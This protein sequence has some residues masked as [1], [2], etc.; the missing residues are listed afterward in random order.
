MAFFNLFKRD[1]SNK[2]A[3]SSF[4]PEW[5][6]HGIAFRLA[7]PLPTPTVDE[8]QARAFAVEQHEFVLAHYLL[9]L[10]QE[11]AASIDVDTIL[12]SWSE[13]YRLREMAEHQSSL[14]SIIVPLERPAQPVLDHLATLSDSSFDVFVEGWE[15]NGR[16]LRTARRIGAVLIVDDEEM[17]LPAATWKTVAIVEQFRLRSAEQRTQHFNELGWG[18]IRA[19]AEVG[20]ALYKSQYLA[21]TH[22]LTPGKLRLPRVK[23]ETAF[24]RVHTVMPTFDGAPTGWLRAFDQY[25]AVQ[26]HYDLASIDGGRVRIVLSEPVRKVLQVIKRD[27][28]GRRV[29]GALAEKFIHN[30]WAFLGE[31]AAEVFNEDDFLLD[32]ASAGPVTTVFSVAP[33]MRD[34]HIDAVSLVVTEHYADGAAQTSEC[35]FD[36]T[37]SL[38]EFVATLEKAL[39]EERE[40]FPWNEFD[41]TVDVE[42]T[43]QL[44]TARQVLFLWRTQP[45]ARI[46][47]TDVYTL[48]DYSDRIHGIGV[49][50]PV[51]V[52]VMQKASSEA[53]DDGGW[54]PD[55]L[56]PMVSV[57]LSGHD[58]HVLIPLT[59]EWVQN[60]EQAVQQAEKE[61]IS[62]V[63]DTEMPTAIDTVQAR[64]LADAFSSMIAAS[65][66]VKAEKASE[67]S[68]PRRTRESLLVKTNF[69]EVDYQEARR[70][71]LTPP[72]DAKVHLPASLRPSISLKTHQR[73]GIAWFQHLVALSPSDC[74]GALLAD[75]MGL[76][77][78]LQLL[79]LLGWFYE[80]QPEGKPSLVVAPK[81]LLENWAQEIERFFTPAFPAHLVLHGEELRARKQPIDLIDEQLQTR[82]VTE[83]LKP[84][85][86]GN[87][88]VIITTYEVLT[89]YEFSF[90]RQEF[91]FVICD[92][93][94]RIKTP[95]TRVTLAAKKLKADFRICC[96]GTPVENSLAD[97]WCLF[98]FV[99][100]GL[101][102]ALETFGRTY[103]RPIECNTEEHHDSL[104]RL[105]L[106][107]APQT[108]RRTK[109]DIA[110]ELKKKYFVLQGLTQSTSSLSVSPADS[111]RLEV[112]ISGHQLV[113]YKGGL[114]KLQDAAVE[115]DAKQRA[116]LSF[117][118][119]HL[120]KAVCAEP[121][122]LPGSRFAPDKR[123]PDAHLE[124]SPKMRWLLE[125]LE[126]VSSRSEKAI[127]FTELREVQAALAY[128]IHQRFGIKPSVVNGDTQARQGIIDR[129]SRSNGF[130]VIILSTL[131]AGAGLNVTAAN[132]VF[133]YT[134]AWNA[135]KEN[136]A[137]D[138]AYR[139]GQERDVFVYCPT[140]VADFPTFEVRLD[141][142]LKRKGKLAGATM[143]NSTMEVMLNGNIEDVRMSELLGDIPGSTRVELTYLAMDDIDRLDGTSFEYFCR[144]L[145]EK[146][147]YVA[148]VTTKTR[149]DGG[150]DVIA[151]QGKEGELLQC[152]SSASAE[153]GWDAVKEVTAGAARYQN[154]YA[155]TRFRR[156]CVTNRRFNVGT[157]AQ[158]DV[159][160]VQLVER[161]EL[162]HLLKQYPVTV[163][164]LDD[165]LM[166]RMSLS[167]AA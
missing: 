98:D 32:K 38:A 133:H 44:E 1:A 109:E 35:N 104:N 61:G 136:Q 156:I 2:A 125:Q 21:T 56:T 55:T 36:G 135:A 126:S 82:G 25:E 17:L 16:S 157:H 140:V 132:H 149:G 158:A 138:R 100:P 162:E 67:P 10:V 80:Q 12:L 163:D 59:E 23:E 70:A 105:Q 20:G 148:S 53:D 96:T 164:E 102:G 110:D 127:V 113:L 42:S 137:T 91:A 27:M 139:I 86:L 30:P 154:T 107:I 85:W 103:R 108:L 9:Q 60:F 81:S 90:A 134:R 48:D 71:I 22:V 14:S 18:N 130:N 143:S 141:E 118:A 123:G 37:A 106:L 43:L 150:I 74:R 145:W 83:L 4:Q 152:K 84:K 7:F 13:F 54:L 88:K 34:G 3:R 101:L 41:L 121:Y 79:T 155:G 39:C 31:S 124:N 112:A 97:L 33:R 69:N 87:H 99:Q 73:Q 115:R 40:Q 111:E 159:N 78:T 26:A 57:T 46:D 129:F 77:K 58:G 153:L 122:C 68:K 160:R 50:K 165:E 65:E 62:E 19:Q 161:G 94:Q 49:A 24:G 120:M 8:L 166:R 51:Y 89:G 11:G 114:K 72:A 116:R 142:M 76:G 92:E 131:A 64:Q 15:L 6:E 144:L 29:A 63:R 52:P 147:G 28:P 66:K 151:L 95:G 119:L 45:A 117:G 5:T 47:F 146:R 75:D 93:A 128:F 167:S